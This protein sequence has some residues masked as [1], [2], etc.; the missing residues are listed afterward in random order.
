MALKASPKYR[1][2]VS[3]QYIFYSNMSEELNER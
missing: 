1:E 3:I 2:V